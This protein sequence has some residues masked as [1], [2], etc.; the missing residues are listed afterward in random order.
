MLKEIKPT[1]RRSLGQRA[2]DF[3]MNHSLYNMF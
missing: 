2:D 1:Y 3:G